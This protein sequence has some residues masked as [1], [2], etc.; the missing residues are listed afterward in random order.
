MTIYNDLLQAKQGARKKLAVLLDPDKYEKGFDKTILLAQDAHV[1]YFLVG[2]SYLLKDRMKEIIQVV[3]SNSNIPIVLFPGSSYQIDDQADA[4]LFLSLISG[5]N[6]ELLIGKHV[7]AAPL[8]RKSNLEVIPTGYILIDGGIQTSVNY[9]SNTKSIP[10]QK[11]EIAVGT[12]MAGEL[13]GLKMIYLE[14]GSGAVNPISSAMIREVSMNISTPLTVGGGIKTP[15]KAIDNI[16]AGADMIV[17][18][19]ILEKD[20][21]IVIDFSAAVHSTNFVIP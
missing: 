13:L 9:M 11:T 12:A 6:P 4:L 18:G 10:H 2:G 21:Q 14:A 15:E 7:E 17:I 19:N 16:K 20:P 8:I 5:R 3:K 1:D